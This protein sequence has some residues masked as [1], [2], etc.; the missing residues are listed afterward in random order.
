MSEIE[1][2]FPTPTLEDLIEHNNDLLLE[3][4][5]Q[6]IPIVQPPLDHTV[7]CNNENVVCITENGKCYKWYNQLYSKQRNIN[8]P[9]ISEVLLPNNEKAKSVACGLAHT[10]IVTLFGNIYT[11]GQ[12]YIGQLG[13]LYIV[14]QIHGENRIR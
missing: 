8:Y 7:A 11:W 9:T 5:L 3:K 2:N 4:T 6:K 1:F 10:V 12:N 13:K 14:K